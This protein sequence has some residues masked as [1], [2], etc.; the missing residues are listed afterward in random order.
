MALWR[1]TRVM[2]ET[3]LS[4]STIERLVAAGAFPPKVAITFSTKGWVSEEIVEWVR[5]RI[6]ARDRGWHPMPTRCSLRLRRRLRFRCPRG[7]PGADP[8]KPRARPGRRA[9]AA[10]ARAQA[11]PV[12]GLA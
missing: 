6:D 9:P 5:R 2:E 4:A 12:S 7:R 10:R 11:C 8:S 1:K 3:G